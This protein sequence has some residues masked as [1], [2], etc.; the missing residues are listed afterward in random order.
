MIASTAHF[1]FTRYNITGK[2]GILTSRPYQISFERLQVI[3]KDMSSWNS[4][5]KKRH[6]DNP[7][8]G[9]SKQTGPAGPGPSGSQGSQP[10]DDEDEEL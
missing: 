1:D 7:E 3:D 2:Q 10:I 8:M 5:P 6:N 4:N 9:R